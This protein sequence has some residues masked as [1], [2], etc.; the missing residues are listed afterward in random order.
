LKHYG[1]ADF[2]K[3]SAKTGLN[4]TARVTSRPRFSCRRGRRLG[5]FTIAGLRHF[6]EKS[7]LDFKFRGLK[8]GFVKS[9]WKLLENLFSVILNEVKDLNFLKIQDSSRCSK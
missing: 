4:T 7:F 3:T 6:F 8:G 9:G 1:Y 2:I 5:F